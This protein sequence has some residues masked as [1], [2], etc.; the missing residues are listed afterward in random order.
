M[1]TPPMT[2]LLLLLLLSS[3]Q[4]PR[5]ETARRA[6][7]DHLQRQEL[8]VFHLKDID[9]ARQVKLTPYRALL[10]T[11]A[12]IRGCRGGRDLDKWMYG[13]FMYRLSDPR[14]GGLQP[15]KV[16][17]YW[18]VVL[19][20]RRFHKM[21]NCKKMSFFVSGDADFS[22]IP[23][24]NVKPQACVT[25]ISVEQGKLDGEKRPGLYDIPFLAITYNS[26]LPLS[27]S[28]HLMRYDVVLDASGKV[29]LILRTIIT[30]LWIS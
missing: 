17:S 22:K 8:Q 19:Q 6:L 7:T 16:G 12:D 1:Y 4:D 26:R 18:Q 29:V 21:R 27:G 9:P 2:E 30:L 14:P 28:G 23:E 11:D 13:N 5:I 15:G 20:V 25:R 3:P 10:M 24:K